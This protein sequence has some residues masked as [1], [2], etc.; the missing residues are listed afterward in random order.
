MSK[1][2]VHVWDRYLGDGRV[3]VAC[4]PV[5]P[6]SSFDPRRTPTEDDLEHATCL[7]CI[8]SVR[9]DALSSA[10]RQ[11]RIASA[12]TALLESLRAKKARR[13]K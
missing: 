13:G 6:Q 9:D 2:K 5:F 4:G 12:A 11:S 10:E 1:R 8:R 3:R 7:H